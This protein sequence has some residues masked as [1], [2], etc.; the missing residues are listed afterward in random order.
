MSLGRLSFTPFPLAMG[1][2]VI[3]VL[4]VRSQESQ[5]GQERSIEFSE[6]RSGVVSSNVNQSGVNKIT[7]KSME[8]DLKKP[9]ELFSTSDDAADCFTAAN[10][11]RPPPSTAKASQMKEL[12]EK[13]NEWIFLTPEDYFA[14][15]LTD[16]KM[17]NLPEFGSDGEE[18]KKKKPLERYYERLDRE[19]AKSRAAT[20]PAEDSDRLSPR[21]IGEKQEGLK[22]LVLWGQPSSLSS[23]LS[24]M[25]Q[26]VK[27]L[28]HGDSSAFGTTADA[29]STARGFSDLF[30]FGK[31]DAGP[32]PEQT[33]AVEARMVEFKQLLDGR[34]LTPADSGAGGFNPLIGSP[35][36]APPTGASAGLNG[37]NG[38]NTRGG[39]SPLSPNPVS[40]TSFPGLPTAAANF[41][42]PPSWQMTP[43]VPETPQVTLPPPTFNIPK[44]KF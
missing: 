25:E 43:P 41:G 27:R 3:V 29:A 39:L 7:L 24:E 28:S 19:S 37:F 44:R 2:A 10:A 8:Q 15:G 6:T 16:E 20:N 30:G 18:T 31:A 17:F 40:Q 32:T 21:Q 9:F 22:E 26:T 14:S 12:L 42:S 34:S 33:S 36:A 35:L 4:S 1:L 5:P 13:R 38:D 11:W 23:G